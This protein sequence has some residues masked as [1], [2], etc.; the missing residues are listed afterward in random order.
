[1]RKIFLMLLLVFSLNA[2]SVNEKSVLNV[3]ITNKP[4]IYS[5]NEDEL[6]NIL[7]NSSE[8]YLILFCGSSDICCQA[9]LKETNNVKINLN[10]PYYYFDVDDYIKNSFE[11]KGTEHFWDFMNKQSL[12]KIPTLQLREGKKVLSSHNISEHGS[13][14]LSQEELELREKN[15]IDGFVSWMKNLK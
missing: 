10:V 15:D 1:M 2:C 11:E 4:T 14:I 12:N 8:K 5:I 7:M 9:I 13:D 6:E 3:D